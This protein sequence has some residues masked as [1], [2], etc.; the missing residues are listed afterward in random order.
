[1]LECK[2][3]TKAYP[4]KGRALRTCPSPFLG[5]RSWACWGRTGRERP[6]SSCVSWA[7]SG[8][9]GAV[10]LDGHPLARADLAKFSFASCEHTF[11]PS[12]TPRAHRDFYAAHFPAFRHNRYAALMDFFALPDH[13]PVGEAL[14]RPAEPV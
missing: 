7:C 2:H 3:L 13:R 12:L 6:P 14:H 9:G 10:T 1:M 4:G 11:F 8:S 5:G